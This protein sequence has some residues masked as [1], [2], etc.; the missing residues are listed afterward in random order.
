[1]GRSSGRLHSSSD[2]SPASKNEQK[3]LGRPRL[4]DLFAEA[5]D[6]A[7]VLSA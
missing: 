2:S 7:T 6:K 3:L 1:M 4:E 5:R